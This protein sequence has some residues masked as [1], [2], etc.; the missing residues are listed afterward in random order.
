MSSEIAIA[1]EN[2]SKVYQVYKKPQDR[3]K[4]ILLKR[5][6]FSEF[7]ALRDI[8]FHVPKGEVVGIIGR[9]G[10]GKSTLLQ[11]IANTLTPSSGNVHV[12]GRIAALLELGSGFNPEFS[13]LENV[14]MNAAILG[15]SREQIDAC[16]PQIEDFAEIGDFIDQP[17][18]I[19]SSGMMVRL[20]FAVSVHVDADILIIDEALAVGDIAFQFKCLHRFEE[21]LAK[22]TTILL[23]SHDVQLVKSYCQ[24]VIYLKNGH[25]AYQGDCETGTELFLMDMRADQ[26]QAESAQAVQ[27]KPA[28]NGAKGMAFGTNSGRILSVEMGSGKTCRQHFQSGERIWVRVTAQVGQDIIHQPR[29]ALVLR[30]ERGYNLFAYDN[31]VLA[32]VLLTPDENGLIEGT[33]TFSCLLQAGNYSL[34]LRLEEFQSEAMNQLLDK[35]VN[36]INFR[37][38]TDKKRFEGVVNLDGKFEAK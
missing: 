24:Q 20:A 19:Y 29:L 7:W 9:N 34:T 15:L 30:D 35:Q 11:L 23:V 13:G 3:I 25:L 27:L 1:V 4:Q 5:Q 36:A 6:Y 14:Y 10:S 28:L 31:V 33:F 16:F 38:L 22:E 37:I 17:V 21:L 8:S 2:I 32:G 12:N 26:Q 18:K